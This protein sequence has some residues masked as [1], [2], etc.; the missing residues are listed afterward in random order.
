MLEN[1]NNVL[2][3]LKLMHEFY[4]GLTLRIYHH[5]RCFHRENLSNSGSVKT[6]GL[7]RKAH[8]FSYTNRNEER[9]EIL[10][11]SVRVLQFS[12]FKV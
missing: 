3:Y 5:F 9:S 12:V 1:I 11:S 2:K 8:I 4:L 10:E 6:Q 7:N